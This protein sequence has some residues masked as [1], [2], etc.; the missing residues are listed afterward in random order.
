[1]LITF[2]FLRND[3]ISY[4]IIK[5]KEKSETNNTTNKFEYIPF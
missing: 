2:Y 5:V 1:M 3:S 4:I